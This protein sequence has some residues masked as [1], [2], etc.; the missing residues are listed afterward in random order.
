VESEFLTHTLNGVATSKLLV[1]P[2]YFINTSKSAKKIRS[3]TC[4]YTPV[5]KYQS[6]SKSRGCRKKS[7]YTCIWLRMR[8]MD[9]VICNGYFV[10]GYKKNNDVFLYWQHGE[11]CPEVIKT[12]NNR[13][14]NLI[15]CNTCIIIIYNNIIQN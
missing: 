14:A 9:K 15:L 10:A 4:H 6:S 7:W 5:A 11:K 12:Y 8:N 13:C 2:K 3:V 1:S